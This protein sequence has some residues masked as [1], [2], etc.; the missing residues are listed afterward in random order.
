M[1]GHRKHHDGDTEHEG[2]VAADDS[3][4]V[5]HGSCAVLKCTAWHF[6]LYNFFINRLSNQLLTEL[7][8]HQFSTSDNSLPLL[9]MATAPSLETIPTELRIMII[10]HLAGTTKKQPRIPCCEYHDPCS[11]DWGWARDA[12]DNALV[13]GGLRDALSMSQVSRVICGEVR[14]TTL[15]S[16]V[17]A[18]CYAWPYVKHELQAGCAVL[19]DVSQGIRG[20]N[21]KWNVYASFDEST[22]EMRNAL[23]NFSTVNGHWKITG[24]QLGPDIE[25]T[26][27]QLFCSKFDNLDLIRFSV[28][29]LN[30]SDNL[31]RLSIC[32][33]FAHGE[34][35]SAKTDLVDNFKQFGQIRADIDMDMHLH[36]M[37]TYNVEDD[38][39]QE[40]Q[41]PVNGFPSVA[42][43]YYLRQLQLA[44]RQNPRND[45]DNS[46]MADWQRVRMW[47]LNNL[48]DSHR[49][50]NDP[51]S[52]GDQRDMEWVDGWYWSHDVQME[53]GLIRILIDVWRAHDRND[54]GLRGYPKADGAIV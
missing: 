44:H 7:L 16:T 54:Q 26:R 46:L 29:G 50:A 6:Q 52:D 21:R 33:E 45:R 22:D 27:K 14:A 10:K 35:L 1:S 53:E 43:K 31:K 9:T 48:P 34:N 25:V 20:L 37:D 12:N 41:M 30:V 8:Y 39:N 49:S 5:S 24:G 38:R 13:P 19:T 17:A 51:R 40:L 18:F 28:D 2:D 23:R 47:A 3:I 42:Q 15:A 36:T 32:C 11:E 4:T